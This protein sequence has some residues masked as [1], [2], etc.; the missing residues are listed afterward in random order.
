MD[1]PPVQLFEQRR[2]LCR[3]QTHHAIFNLRPAED[4]I[5]KSFG[6]Q[7]RAGAMQKKST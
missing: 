2:E 4:A 3:R 6:E 1:A 5:L 7:A